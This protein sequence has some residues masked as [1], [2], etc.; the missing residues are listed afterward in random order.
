MA[1]APTLAQLLMADPPPMTMSQSM[2]KL[3]K[4]HNAGATVAD[5][6]AGGWG[7]AAGAGLYSAHPAGIAASIPLGWLAY[8]AHRRANGARVDAERARQGAEMWDKT[9][10]PEFPTR[11]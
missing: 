6:F 2:Q 5:V 7:A 4:Q 10:L 1:D 11:D 3:A 9:G 8:E